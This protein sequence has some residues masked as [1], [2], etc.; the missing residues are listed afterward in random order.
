MARAGPI[1]GAV[2]TV[3][4]VLVSC[5]DDSP[6][7]PPEGGY[8]IEFEAHTSEPD[9]ID[10]SGTTDLPDGTEVSVV[11]ARMLLNPGGDPTNPR[12]A[13]LAS[14]TAIVDSGAY[15]ATL[16]LDDTHL[17]VGLDSP[18]ESIEVVSP[19]VTVCSIV[20]TGTDFEDQSRQPNSSV[21]DAIGDNGEA[22][23]GSDGAYIFGSATDTPSVWL[24]VLSEIEQGSPEEEIVQ[25]QGSIPLV[26]PIDGFCL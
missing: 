9:Q 1:L 18:G 12:G 11:A 14:E 20:M 4:T 15:K 8:S 10:V 5:G 7:Q 13:N 24:E 19:N 16:T 3:A 26:E 22:L 21:R 25:E 2:T 23:E 6:P 17:L